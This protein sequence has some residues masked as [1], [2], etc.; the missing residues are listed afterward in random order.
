MPHFAPKL[1]MCPV[2]LSPASPDVLR[3]A[4]LFAKPYQARI[5]VLLAEWLEYPP[6]FLPSQIAELEAMAK[7]NRAALAESL[8]HLANQ[9]VPEGTSYKISVLEDHPIEAILKHGEQEKVD[10]IVMGSHGRTGFARMKL[11]S[12][13]ESVVQQTSVPTLVVRAQGGKPAASNIAR[14]LCPVKFSEH[15]GRSLAFS[16]EV[17]SAFGAQLIVMHVEER[18][19]NL[20]SSRKQL[21]EA[22]PD[23]ARKRCN[24]IEVARAGEPA[25][26]ILLAAR[27]HAADLIVLTALHRRFLEFSVLGTT[28]EKVL[29]HADS[30]ILVLPVVKEA[31][32]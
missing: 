17:A 14:I 8:E 30:A 3:W 7:R 11:G 31:S 23:D 2:D 16:A 20:A 21:C 12:V 18:G 5:E 6:Y 28:T 15:T 9:N 19:G 27:E 29:R 13:A 26:Q 24:V 25:E 1:I 22:V 4:A 10:L 32:A